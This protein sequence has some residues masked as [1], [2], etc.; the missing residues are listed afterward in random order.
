MTQETVSERNGK[1][2]QNST[3]SP[4]EPVVPEEKTDKDASKAPSPPLGWDP[5]VPPTRA[6]PVAP[7]GWDP[8]VPPTRATPVA[9]S[10]WDPYA[11]PSR[12]V[13]PGGWDPYVPPTRALPVAPSGWDPYVPPSR[14]VAPNGWDPYQPPA[15][16]GW[17][18]Y[19]PPAR[20]EPQ[21]L[22][23][24]VAGPAH[25]ESE[26]EDRRPDAGGGW[27]QRALIT[28]LWSAVENDGVWVAIHGVGWRQLSSA[29]ESGHAHLATL[30]LLAMNHRLPVA[31]HEDS[32]GHIDQ[33][34]V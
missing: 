6:T 2:D 3:A 24:P 25:V 10:G 13:V 32:R 20:V 34:L 30:A 18:P 28:R 22:S 31:Y 4:N 5:Y 17:D 27:V 29:S 33:L 16:A 8:Y 9:P 14:P 15:P 23:G 12:P 1:A 7:S 26:G 11:P 21:P 19:Q